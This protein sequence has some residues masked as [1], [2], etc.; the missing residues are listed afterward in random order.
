MSLILSYLKTRED[1]QICRQDLFMV[2]K[3]IKKKYM[4]HCVIIHWIKLKYISNLESITV[5]IMYFQRLCMNPVS[6][7]SAF[8]V[9]LTGD[10]YTSPVCPSVTW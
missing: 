5:K 2:N 9:S 8:T 6:S 7:Y 1:K 10:I 3:K 4:T